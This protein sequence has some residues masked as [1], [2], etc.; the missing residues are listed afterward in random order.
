VALARRIGRALQSADVKK[1]DLWLADVIPTFKKV[2]RGKEG[3]RRT[4]LFGLCRHY[5]CSV[6]AAI[7]ILA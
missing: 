5:Y 4:L 3:A 2:F 7:L 6:F 1:L